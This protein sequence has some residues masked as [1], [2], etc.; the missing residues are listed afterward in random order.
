M[1]STFELGILD[2]YTLRGIITQ[3]QMLLS[4]YI[5]LK[6]DKPG[7]IAAILVN[8]INFLSSLAFI[9]GSKTMVPLPGIIS[10]LSTLLLLYS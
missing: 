10:Y 5:V 4:I 7:F 2:G 1:P 3:L 9:I 6:E 8:G